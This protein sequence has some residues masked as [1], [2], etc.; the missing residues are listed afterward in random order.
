MCYSMSCLSNYRPRVRKT[1]YILKDGLVLYLFIVFD[2]EI[3]F[4]SYNKTQITF[5]INNTFSNGFDSKFM[6][7]YHLKHFYCLKILIKIIK[8]TNYLSWTLLNIIICLIFI[9][10]SNPKY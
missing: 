6:T 10:H 5:Y 4:D 3:C 1:S 7:K 2:L 9:R 8:M